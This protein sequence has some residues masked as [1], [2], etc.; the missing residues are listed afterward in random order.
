MHHTQFLTSIKGNNLE[1]FIN[2][3]I[4]CP[5]QFHPYTAIG[6]SSSSGSALREVNPNFT[7]W[8]KIDQLLL[9]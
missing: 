2:G 6:A 1:R 7:T 9:S 8:I 3:Y 4:V 5:K